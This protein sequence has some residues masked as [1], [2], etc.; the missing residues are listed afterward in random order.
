MLQETID[1]DRDMLKAFLHRRDPRLDRRGRRPGRRG[2]ARR[3]DLRQGPRSSTCAGQTEQATAQNE[4][5]VTADTEANGL[6][7]LTDGAA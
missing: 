2:Q 7:T 4:L 3:R 6:F 1:N 5:I